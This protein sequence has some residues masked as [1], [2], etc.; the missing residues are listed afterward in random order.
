[1][2]VT[3]VIRTWRGTREASR[4]KALMTK[5]EQDGLGAAR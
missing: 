1:M 3:R 5:I 2:R 4:L